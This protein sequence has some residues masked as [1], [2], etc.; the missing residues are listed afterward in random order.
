MT[1]QAQRGS[2]P[3]TFPPLTFDVGDTV[4]LGVDYQQGFGPTGMEYTP[5]APA[6][7]AAFRRA[8]EAWR[9]H[10][11]RVIHVHSTREPA[12]FTRDD[13]TPDERAYAAHPM[14]RGSPHAQFYPDLVDD[15]DVVTRK[16]VFSA[17]AGSNLIEL[18]QENGWRQVI[19][20][21]LTTP[22]CVGTTADA[23]SMAGFVVGV[24]S[25]ASASQPIGEYS[26]ELMHDVAIARFGYLF[27]HVLTTAEFVERV[28]AG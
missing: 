3:R 27:G 12:D 15:A 22:I 24:L 7:V 11:G 26:A 6:A 14:R 4:L 19:I 21:G 2:N 8:A 16:T 9:G 25:D 1:A 28:T 17:V 23:L 18:L 5:H 10:G 20:G 13:G